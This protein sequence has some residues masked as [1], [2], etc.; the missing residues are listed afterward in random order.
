MTQRRPSGRLELTWTNKDGR[1]LASDDGSYDWVDPSDYRVS[2]VRLLRD[3]GTVGETSSDRNR[4]RDNLLIR[5]DALYALTSLTS[6]PEFADEYRG[7]VKLVYIDPP[8]NTGE[9][10]AQYDD[11]LEHSIW[12]TMM[13]DRLTQIMELLTPDGSVWV[14]LDDTEQHRARMVLDEVFGI[15]CF[16]STIIW[17]KVSGRDNRKAISSNHDYLIVYSPNPA[18]W[19]ETRNGFPFGE[20]Q[21]ARYRNPDNDPRGPWQSGDLTAQAGHATPA[22]FY[23]ITTPTGRRLDPPPGRCWL[24]TEERFRELVAD[25][26]IWFG[27]TGN[28]A[29]RIKRFLSEVEQSLTPRSIWTADEAGTNDQAKKEILAMF[30]DLEPFATP[31]PE[32]LMERIIHVATNPGDIVLDCFAGSGTTAAV[33]HKMKRR[34]VAVEWFEDTLREFTIPRLTRVVTGEDPGGVTESTGWSGGGGFRILD[35]APSMFCEIEDVIYLADW[36]EDEALAEPV[37]AQWGFRH[38]PEPPFAGKKGRTYLAVVDGL[39]NENVIDLLADL[40]P[41]GHSL[42]VAGTAVAPGA[43]EHVRTRIPGGRVRKVP[44]S[45]LVEY[46]SVYLRRRRRELKLDRPTADEK[47]Q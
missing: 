27:K 13:R 29:P 46:R 5:G 10:F 40:L 12:L 21:L 24:V 31:K 32:R 44:E 25:N 19:K 8:F 3:A 2:E 36:A 38:Q 18:A 28:N 9:T 6:L 4:V 17:E 1:L 16:V 41:E 26:R 37:A 7:R 35:V 34:W 43:D 20:E 39:V 15:S 22:Q 45:I 11:N 33:A 42:L 30:P 14:H 47:H 23:T